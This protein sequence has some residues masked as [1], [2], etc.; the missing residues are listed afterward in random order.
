MLVTESF[1]P[2]VVKA[3]KT[4]HRCILKTSLSTKSRAG[5]GG[6]L[7]CHVCLASYSDYN[8]YFRHLVDR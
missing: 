3:P 5:S 4:I 2:P 1:A 8:T 7:A 6:Q